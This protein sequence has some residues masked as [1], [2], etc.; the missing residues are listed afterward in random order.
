MG[1]FGCAGGFRVGRVS[2]L[3]RT[4]C[5]RVGRRLCDGGGVGMLSQNEGCQHDIADEGQ[6]EDDGA[7]VHAGCIC[8]SKRGVNLKLN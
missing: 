4:N 5:F 6:A 7:R 8:V 3:S 2:G 1:G